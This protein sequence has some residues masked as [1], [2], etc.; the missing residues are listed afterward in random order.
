MKKRNILTTAALTVGTL[1]IAVV[2]AHAGIV[3]GTL[4]NLGL[5][6]NISLLNSNVNSDPTTTENNNAN[7]RADGKKNN[8]SDQN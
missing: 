1:A 8:S 2:P 5:L 3:D 7:T 4:N 6:D